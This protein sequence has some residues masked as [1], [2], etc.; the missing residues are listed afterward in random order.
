MWYC[1]PPKNDPNTKLGL[2]LYLFEEHL[3]HVMKFN[4][5]GLK[6]LV[7]LHTMTVQHPRPSLAHLF[8][9]LFR[10]EGSNLRILFHDAF[11]FGSIQLTDSLHDSFSFGSIQLT[12]S[13]HDA[14]TLVRKHPMPFG[15][16][17]HRLKFNDNTH[18]TKNGQN[19]H[20][21]K[22][23]FESVLLNPNRLFLLLSR[24]LLMRNP[25]QSPLTTQ[26]HGQ[27]DRNVCI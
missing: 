6:R 5:E 14:T 17:Q 21:M 24:Y 10:S 3:L 19:F 26:D 9:P 23:D 2:C 7:T 8:Y 1:P 20:I 25:P 11:S 12:D 18:D 27:N 13:L 16:I 4:V 15:A 22:S